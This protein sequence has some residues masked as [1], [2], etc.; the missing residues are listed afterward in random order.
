MISQ[1]INNMIADN[2]F[3]LLDIMLNHST[4]HL[5][6]ESS[7]MEKLRRLELQRIAKIVKN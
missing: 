3:G 4:S 2:H 7:N 1:Q 6:I 5:E